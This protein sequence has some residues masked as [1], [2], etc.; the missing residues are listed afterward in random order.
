MKNIKKLRR[1]R[2]LTQQ[3]LGYHVGMAAGDISRIESGR[4]IPYPGQAKK[5][6]EF[7]GCEIDFL[8]EES[9]TEK[10]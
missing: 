7:F 10:A 8:L 9:T 4:L 5:L 3:S 2:E 1:D 6:S